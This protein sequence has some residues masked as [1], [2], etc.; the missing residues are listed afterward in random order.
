MPFL[1]PLPLSCTPFPGH[2]SWG[3]PMM[4]P[5]LELWTPP[6]GRGF[7]HHPSLSFSPCLHP[8]PPVS[9]SPSQPPHLD[10][11]P[12]PKELCKDRST[13]GMW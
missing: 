8:L 3:H 6:E 12:Q 7:E 10:P 4:F 9:S 2:V 13:Q 1:G 11:G 5:E